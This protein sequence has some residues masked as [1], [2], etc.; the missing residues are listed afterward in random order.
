M[1]RNHFRNNT[2]SPKHLNYRGLFP[3]K[4]VLRCRQS[5][6]WT[7]N[8]IRLKD[9]CTFRWSSMKI[10][11]KY[12]GRPIPN[13]FFPFWN[14]CPKMQMVQPKYF[15][16]ESVATIITTTKLGLMILTWQKFINLYSRKPWQMSTNVFC[17]WSCVLNLKMGDS[18]WWSIHQVHMHKNISIQRSPSR[19]VRLWKI[20]ICGCILN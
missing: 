5:S 18:D 8:A 4:S 10:S 9:I 20:S 17:V 19:M 12:L 2:A 1:L 14:R 6:K 13:D 7:F 16:Q 11:L 3:D 15:P